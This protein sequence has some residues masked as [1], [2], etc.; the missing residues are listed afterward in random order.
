MFIPEKLLQKAFFWGPLFIGILSLVIGVVFVRSVDDVDGEIPL[1]NIKF[2]EKESAKSSV[3][4]TQVS[5]KELDRNIAKHSSSEIKVVKPKPIQKTVKTPTV[6]QK[7]LSLNSRELQTTKSTPDT[8]KTIKTKEDQT[9]VITIPQLVSLHSSLLVKDVAVVSQGFSEI[10]RMPYQLGVSHAA[11]ETANWAQL[12]QLGLISSTLRSRDVSVIAEAD[13]LG[14]KGQEFVTGMEFFL[15]RQRQPLIAHYSNLIATNLDPTMLRVHKGSLTGGVVTHSYFQDQGVSFAR[16]PI[17]I[18]KGMVTSYEGSS[19]ILQ[20]YKVAQI[21]SDIGK[22]AQSLTAKGLQRASLQAE[23]IKLTP[24][25]LTLTEGVKNDKPVSGANNLNCSEKFY[26]TLQS[27]RSSKIASI[28]EVARPISKINKDLPGK[29]IFAPRKLRGAK[30]CSRYKTYK[31]GAK[32]C[33]KWTRS[34]TLKGALTPD[35]KEFILTAQKLISGRG[36]HPAVKPRSPSHWVINIVAKNLNSYTSQKPHPAICTG[37]LSMVKYFEG[38]LTKF[39]KHMLQIATLEGQSKAHILNQVEKLNAVLSKKNV[40]LIKASEFKSATQNQRINIQTTDP[41]TVIGQA[42]AALFGEDIGI[43]ILTQG[44]FIDA[45]QVTRTLIT[46]RKKH[47]SSR[48]YSAFHQLASILEATYYIQQTNEKY[49]L[50]NQKLFGSLNDIRA[51]HST[52]CTCS[53]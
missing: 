20:N 14:A 49:K 50:L 11:E 53:N 33:I 22:Q 38:N 39:K 18:A 48:T 9:V 17:I 2:D 16:Y 15:Q 4:G 24:V 42:A 36:R 30:T 3:S 28:K 8:K 26:T 47:L 44:N 34:S 1:A 12:T 52:H 32:K 6:G 51:A 29:W 35:E 40:K 10:N 13:L 41:S 21:S 45:L 37:A 7:T 46:A 19:E 43:E 5:T 31:S 25:A 23:A 27:I